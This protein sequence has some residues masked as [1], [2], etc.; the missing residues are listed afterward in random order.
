MPAAPAP[1]ARRAP[2]LALLL[3]RYIAGEVAETQLF[4]LTDLFDEADASA[5]E[6]TAFARFYLDALAAEGDVRLPKAEELTALLAVAR[7]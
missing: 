6:R 7:A 2:A 5:P 3:A 1:V 4:G